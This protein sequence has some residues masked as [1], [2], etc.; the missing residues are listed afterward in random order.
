MSQP[1]KWYLSK[2]IW[3]NGL[4]AAVAVLTALQGQ[5]IIQDYPR[6]SAAVVAGL[7]VLNIGLRIITYLPLE[8]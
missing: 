6:A 5:A 4:S 2:T 8:G 7:G 1:K 3:V